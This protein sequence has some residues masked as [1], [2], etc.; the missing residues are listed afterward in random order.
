MIFLNNIFLSFIFI[1][2]YAAQPI[3]AAISEKV[4]ICGVCRNV[5]K[6]LP[7][8]I[9][10]MEQIGALFDDYQILVYENNSVDR[11]PLL[12]NQWKESNPKVFVLSEQ[13]AER[14]LKEEIINS[15]H[16]GFYRPELIARA[17]NIVLDIAMSDACSEFTHLIWM[18]MD[19]KI[20]PAFEGIIETFESQ[21]EWDAVLAYGIDPPG[22]YWD[23]Y[24]FRNDQYP[25]GSELLGNHWWYMPKHFQ[26]KKSDAWYP[27]YSA[28]GGCGIYKKAAIKDCRYSA[29][30][31][32]DLEILALELIQS[33]RV[34]HH[35]Q[36][37]KYDELR[38]QA[39][40]LICLPSPYP[41]MP[42][43]KNPN[44]GIILFSSDSPLVWRMS[45]FVYQYPSVCEHV[46]FHASMI[47]RG[48]DKI[49]INPR[50]IFTY[51][52]Y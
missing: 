27:V 34:S 44:T 29:I 1:L 37:K 41:G 40:S 14:E 47:L 21:V 52:G 42:Q 49:F 46:P 12:L 10:I 33:G 4:L 7:F 23:W 30:V 26:L 38:G 43:I 51:G 8:T 45:S 9:E 24:A 2:L 15:N 11:T 48:H 18:D 6:P 22:T 19:F 50:L 5:E 16:E 39:L 31:T 20:P 13:I 35:P 25:I 28:F 32:E 36:I 17:R 3:T